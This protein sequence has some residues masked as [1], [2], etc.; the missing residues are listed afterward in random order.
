MSAGYSAQIYLLRDVEFFRAKVS[1]MD[2]HGH[3]KEDDHLSL[4]T[5]S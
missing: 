2:L 3:N 4:E 1:E 5:A